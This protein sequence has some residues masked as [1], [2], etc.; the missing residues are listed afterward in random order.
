[1]NIAQHDLLFW[2]QRK[3]RFEELLNCFLLHACWSVVRLGRSTDHCELSFFALLE[4][5]FSFC[6]FFLTL[7]VRQNHNYIAVFAH[8]RR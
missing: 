1:M 5:L 6:I 3:Q 7:G 8:I 2:S 4:L